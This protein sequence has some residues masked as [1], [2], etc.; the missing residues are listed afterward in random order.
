MTAVED[1]EGVEFGVPQTVWHCYVVSEGAV[2]FYV[3]ADTRE[4][5]RRHATEL[6]DD[7]SDWGYD[8]SVESVTETPI[9][10]VDTRNL[11]PVWVGGEHGY[12][13][14]DL[15]ELARRPQRYEGQG[16][17]DLD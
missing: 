15:R 1:R 5:A 13:T 2:E 9:E 12:W 6:A 4:E 17:L 3:A 14:E 8:E 10:R 11:G 7:F 16:Q